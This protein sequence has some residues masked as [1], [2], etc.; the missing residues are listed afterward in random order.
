LHTSQGGWG[1]HHCHGSLPAFDFVSECQGGIAGVRL[2]GLVR[3]ANGTA[4]G[5]KGEP[6]GG[7]GFEILMEQDLGVLLG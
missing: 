2:A 1:G 4:G 7:S 5:A 6:A 3:D